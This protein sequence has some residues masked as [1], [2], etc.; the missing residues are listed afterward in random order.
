MFIPELSPEDVKFAIDNDNVLLLD[1][2]SPLEHEEV[3]IPNSVLIP[4]EKLSFSLDKLPKDRKIIVYCKSGNRSAMATYIL[5]SKG[6]DAYNM[7]GGIVSWS[8]E[9]VGKAVSPIS[10]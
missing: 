8:Y 3:C 10:L 5:R 9:K 6:F 1:V 7:R 2:R 4:L